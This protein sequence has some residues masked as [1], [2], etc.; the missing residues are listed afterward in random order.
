MKFPFNQFK[1][2]DSTF[3][4][5]NNLTRFQSMDDTCL[6][7]PSTLENYYLVCQPDL[8]FEYLVSFLMKHK[9]DKIL[10]FLSTCA[11]TEYFSLMLERYVLN[12]FYDAR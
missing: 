10:V 1:Q 4:V 12:A 5:F 3:T 11:G 7:T 9:N 2:S 6:K 8:K